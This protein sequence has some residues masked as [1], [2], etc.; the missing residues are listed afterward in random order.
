MVEQRDIENGPDAE[1]LLSVTRT[2]AMLEAL[3]LR[4]DGATP[5]ELSQALGLHLSTCYRL[6][7]TLVAAGYVIR[8][9]GGGLFRIGPRVAFLN[10]GFLATVQPPADAIPFMHALQVTTG[11]TTILGQLV[12]DDVVIVAGVAG[13]RPGSLSPGY[14]GLTAPA[15]GMAIGRALLAWLPAAKRESY[16]ARRARQPAP[17]FPLSEPAAFRSELEQIRASGV[18]LDHGPGN[19]DFCCVAA[20]VGD[21]S[22]GTTTAIA[23]VGPCAR[24]APEEPALVAAVLAVA[25]AIG[26]VRPARAAENGRTGSDPVGSGSPARTVVEGALAAIEAAMSRIR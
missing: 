3:S 5:K 7:N 19:P 22:N 15:H 23:V 24:F 25:R 12:G 21:T 11:E 17:L 1:R 2:L 13:S 8:R 16:L 26:A 6:L 10:H 14:T 9:E 18:A 4:P 20:P